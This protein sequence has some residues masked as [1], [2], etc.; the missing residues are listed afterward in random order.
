M[1]MRLCATMS[2][3][4]DK[5]KRADTG[6]KVMEERLH[7]RPSALSVNH[8]SQRGLDCGVSSSPIELSG[9]I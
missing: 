3:S 6:N 1:Q 5:H 2:V 9:L 8:Q 7:K 4:A